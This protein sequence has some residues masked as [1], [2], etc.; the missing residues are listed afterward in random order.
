M[1]TAVKSK[2]LDFSYSRSH[3]EPRGLRQPSEPFWDLFTH[4][5]IRH[6]LE[7]LKFKRWTIPS[8][9]EVAEQLETS[10][11]AGGN[12]KRY[13]HSGEQLGSFLWSYTYTYHTTQSSIPLLGMYPKEMKIQVRTKSYTRMPTAASFIKTPNWQQPKR[14]QQGLR[15]KLWYT[16]AMEYYLPTQRNELLTQAT[17]WIR[18]VDV[19]LRSQSQKVT[20]CMIP[21]IRHSQKDKATRMDEPWRVGSGR[22][23]MQREGRREDRGVMKLFYVLVEVVA[24]LI[25]NMC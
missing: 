24:T 9:G 11:I 12:A 16:H 7:W 8:A 19:T 23:W 18:P 14:S 6:D 4:F 15:N 22:V 2:G 21:F 1:Y 20:Y 13:S 10:S 25:Y 3:Q 17:T 5:K